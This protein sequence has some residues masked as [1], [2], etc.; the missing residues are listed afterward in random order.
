[1]PPASPPSDR[2]PWAGSGRRERVG[3]SGWQQAKDARRIL[4]KHKGYCHWC[5]Q[6]GAD[7]VDHIVPTA[8]GGSDD[9]SNKAPIHSVPCHREKTQAE[10]R[11]AR[12]R[13][14]RVRPTEAHP[15]QAGGG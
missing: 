7:E 1:M 12:E 10:A 6:P 14:S 9:D 13:K 11:S 5:G 3:K 8:E 15:G 2:T 4:E